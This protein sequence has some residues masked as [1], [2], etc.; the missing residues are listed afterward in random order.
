MARG[1]NPIRC[2]IPSRVLAAFANLFFCFLI[3]ERSAFYLF[4]DQSQPRF[5]S[6]LPPKPP[7][8]VPPSPITIIKT[9]SQLSLESDIDPIVA[10]QKRFIEETDE[11]ARKVD[12]FVKASNKQLQNFQI[13][14]NNTELVIL[15]LS[16]QKEKM[17]G[18][19]RDHYKGLT[20]HK[21]K[22]E[23]AKQEEEVKRVEKIL[24]PLVTII[25]RLNPH[26]DETDYFRYD[27]DSTKFHFHL[28]QIETED[29][30]DDDEDDVT[31]EED[32]EEDDE[33]DDEDDYEEE[34]QPRFT[35]SL[36]P[37]PPTQVPPSPITIIKTKSQLSLES[38]IDPIVAMQKRFIEETDE[39]ARKVDRFVKASNKQLQN[40]QIADNNTELVILSLSLQKEKMLGAARDH[41][42][43]LTAHKRKLEMAKQEEE[44]KR[45][46]KILAPLVTIIDRLNPHADETDYFRYDNDST[47][48]HFH[49]H[50]I[51]TEDME[52][53]DEDD[54]TLEEDEE[55]DDE[56]D[57][58]DDY[59]EDVDIEEDEEE[60]EDE[61]DEYTETSE[62]SSTF[63]SVVCEAIGNY[64][65]AVGSNDLVA[66][67]SGDLSIKKGDKLV[68]RSQRR[69]GW[70]EAENL[71]TGLVGLIPSNFVKVTNYDVPT[72]RRKQDTVERDEK[73]ERLRSGQVLNSGSRPSTISQFMK[74]A[75]LLTIMNLQAVPL[76]GGG[77]FEPNIEIDDTWQSKNT[78]GRTKKPQIS[79][80]ISSISRFKHN[81]HNS[82]RKTT[83]TSHNLLGIP[84][85]RNLSILRLTLAARI[86][87]CQAVP[88]YGG[89]A[90]EPNIE[91]DDT[92]QSKN[93]FGR[94]K[95]PQISINISS[96]SRFKHNVVSTLPSTILTSTLNIKTV[97]LFRR[98]IGEV[99]LKDNESS[100]NGVKFNP[101]IALMLQMADQPVLM[102]LF[103]RFYTE[104]TSE[105]RRADKGDPKYMRKHLE[106]VLKNHIW[107][108][109]GEDTECELTRDMIVTFVTLAPR[110]N[111]TKI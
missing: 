77:A 86:R 61:E 110:S 5:T 71:E 19:A 95:K 58:E 11:L 16:L 91:I 51:E 40:F 29:M 37:K 101:T 78:F 102:D 25:D 87:P 104:K 75:V 109:M 103:K 79:I 8:Q 14:D 9:K 27:N 84:M 44:V 57:D 73:F 83:V 85:L 6:S 74:D 45:V 41:Y 53:D 97:S 31:L 54:V 21:R 72:R 42:K 50:Q 3:F 20:A 48:F 108:G 26:A 52:D 1:V 28:H 66:M 10:M 7:T 18:A 22:L 107:P 106:D 15:S 111:L 88:L 99:L 64:N 67:E 47:K 2:L 38:D 43:G 98:V 90:F 62:P 35:S 69:D 60:D 4:E 100:Q 92:W 24:A 46:E 36:P 94:T 34:S 63:N 89:G 70:W 39:L 30:E 56:E 33:E 13:A 23:L 81:L 12:R 82:L 32:E 65:A 96:I 105:L 59:E 68:I 55:E 17:L 93:T 76:Y 80:N 49:L